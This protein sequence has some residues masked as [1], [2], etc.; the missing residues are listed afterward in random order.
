MYRDRYFE[1]HITTE[2]LECN[3]IELGLSSP[4]FDPTQ[5]KQCLELLIFFV[6]D[7][8]FVLFVNSCNVHVKNKIFSIID[9]I[10]SGQQ[11]F[12]YKCMMTKLANR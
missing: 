7:F 6:N 12:S 11:L 8:Q 2:V 1:L 4:S 3:L 10:Y 5:S 9:L